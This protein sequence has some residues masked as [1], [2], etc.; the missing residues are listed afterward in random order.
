VEL[1]RIAFEAA[2]RRDLDA[3]MSLL[4][5]NAVWDESPWGW[6]AFEGKTVIRGFFE[7]WIASYE[8]LVFELEE[9]VELGAGVVV[10]VIR[11]NHRLTGSPAHLP[12]RHPVV[13]VWDHGAAVRVTNYRD[14]DEA[15]AAAERL[16][17]ERG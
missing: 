14:I 9:I 3:V 8:E 15:R 6:G 1:T 16:A 17:Q 11:Q 12:V 2:N 5:T 13:I 4:S 7:D 10:A